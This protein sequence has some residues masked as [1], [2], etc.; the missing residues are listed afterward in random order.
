MNMG[1]LNPSSTANLRLPPPTIAI[2]R[3]ETLSFPIEI[4]DSSTGIVGYSKTT[5]TR[6]VTVQCIWSGRLCDLSTDQHRVERQLTELGYD[7]DAIIADVTMAAVG[8]RIA[9]RAGESIAPM[10]I[11]RW[12]ANVRMGGTT[13]ISVGGKDVIRLAVSS[14]SKSLTSP[15]LERVTASYQGRLPWTVTASS[16][17]TMHEQDAERISRAQDPALEID[18]LVRATAVPA[19]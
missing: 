18:V 5:E 11:P 8:V 4:G 15:L 14:P 2:T 13:L 1:E 10:F 17:L 7:P 12:T 19:A 3:L 9:D 16:R 6:R